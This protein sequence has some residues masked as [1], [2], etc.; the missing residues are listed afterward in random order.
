[1]PLLVVGPTV[2]DGEV[3][4][5]SAA[6]AV[7]PPAASA[8]ATVVSATSARRRRDRIKPFMSTPPSPRSI[9]LTLRC[10]NA[11]VSDVTDRKASRISATASCAIDDGGAYRLLQRLSARRL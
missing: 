8:R 10:S 7:R 4:D 5:V 11:T 3:V 9:Q 1:M 2:V 6:H